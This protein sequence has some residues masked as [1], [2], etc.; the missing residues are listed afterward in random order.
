MSSS[1]SLPLSS[2]ESE[3][4][5]M[6]DFEK[7]DSQPHTLESTKSKIP[8]TYGKNSVS[9]LT[10][11]NDIATNTMNGRIGSKSWCKCKCCALMETSIEGVSYLEMS[12]ISKP[13]FSSTLCLN[14]CRSDPH[15]VL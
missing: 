3:I 2:S 1:K 8:V 10:N 14:V 13:R 12:V 5:R 6:T 15:F 9:D 4:G 7:F 11:S